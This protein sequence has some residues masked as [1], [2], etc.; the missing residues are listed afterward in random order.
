MVGHVQASG[1]GRTGREH[2]ADRDLQ[3]SPSIINLEPSTPTLLYRVPTYP[4]IIGVESYSYLLFH[5][6]IWLLT[7][8]TE[9]PSYNSECRGQTRSR[10]FITCLETLRA[11]WDAT[12]A[13]APSHITQ[14][15]REF[16]P[17]S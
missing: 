1:S 6:H 9:V 11:S 10:C 12:I 17:F 14:N 16:L 13:K 2:F 7:I 8:G 5:C 15:R 3:S 4:G